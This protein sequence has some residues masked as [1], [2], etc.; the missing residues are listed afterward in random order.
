MNF[1]NAFAVYGRDIE[2]KHT[3]CHP[4]VCPICGHAVEPVPLFCSEIRKGDDSSLLS[5]MFLCRHCNDTFIANYRD[6]KFDLPILAPQGSPKATFE[7]AIE[8]LSPEFVKIYN[9]TLA[10]ESAGLDELVGI[11]YRKALEYLIKDYLIRVLPEEESIIRKM[12]LGNCIANKISNDRLKVVASRAA[13]LGNDFTHY[14]RHFT[15]FEID[16]LK[17]F[18]QAAQY[19]IIAEIT[20]TEALEIQSRR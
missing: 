17:R 19:W 12:E 9:Q 16:D 3:V 20:V 11:G 8:K 1:S 2:R 7:P 14:T 10:A 4:G 13:W 18:I 6:N 5:I 15:D